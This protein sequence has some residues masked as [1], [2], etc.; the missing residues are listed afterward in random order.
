MNTPAPIHFGTDGWRAVIAQDMT[1]D[2]VARV[3]KATVDYVKERFDDPRIVIGHDCRFAGDLFVETAAKVFADHGIHVV[4]PKDFISTPMLSLATREYEASLGVILT[5]SHNPPEYNG[6]KLRGAYGGALT[7][8]QVAE[9]EKLVPDEV[10]ASH[11]E[12]DL[13]DL[14]KEG[15]V[16]VADIEKLYCDR[17]KAGFDIDAIME[18]DMTLAYDAMF[19]AG[20]RVFD[21]IFPEMVCLHCEYNPS[22]KGTPPEP[23]EKNLREFSEYIKDRMEIDCGLATDGD[24]DRLGLFNGQGRFIDSHHI[25]LLVIHYL[26]AHKGMSGKVVTAFSCSEKIKKLCEHYGLEH[27]TVKIGFKHIV[28]VMQKEDVLLGGEESGGIAIKG[29]IPERDGIWIGMLLWEYMAKTGNSLNELI[30]E[31]YGIVGEF[32]FQRSDLHIKEDVKQRIIEDCKNGRYERFGDLE[33]QRVE[34]LDGYKYYFNDDEWVMIRPSGTEPVLRTYAEA[35]DKQRA[36]A[37]I[38]ACHDTILEKEEVKG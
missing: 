1:T 37:I 15:A 17:I 35:K 21:H 19:G 34:T 20:Q 25:I 23:I 36:K 9:V 24:A 38:Q 3:A 11:Q 6:Y 32:A 8:D 5:A 29:H 33:V 7:P 26:V 16:E 30:R 31:V 2:N 13:E 4:I 22:F 14:K 12:R 18:S 27:Q 28:E 10:P